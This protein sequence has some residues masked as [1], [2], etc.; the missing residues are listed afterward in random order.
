[1]HSHPPITSL[2]SQHPAALL[3]WATLSHCV[4]GIWMH[5]YFKVCITRVEPTAAGA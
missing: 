4:L 1:M 3:P 2:C 5:T